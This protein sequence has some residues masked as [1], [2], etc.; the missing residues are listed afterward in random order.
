MV[1]FQN[2]QQGM[3]V[4]TV[5]QAQRSL[6]K[7]TAS[8]KDGVERESG[9]RFTSLMHLEYFNCVRYHIID[10]MHNLFGLELST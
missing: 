1:G 6:E 4:I 5:R 3:K 9:S 2:V 7:N 8:S 10:P